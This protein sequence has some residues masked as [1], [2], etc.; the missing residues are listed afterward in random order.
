ME[1]TENQK[2][3]KEILTEVP[4][5]V[6]DLFSFENDWVSLSRWPKLDGM[7][8]HEKAM[9]AFVI[10][11]YSGTNKHYPKQH[12]LEHFGGMDLQKRQL[13]V[14]WCCKPFWL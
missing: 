13:I 11:I 5:W 1:L 12:I 6:S 14:D 8:P 4:R 3:F 9:T 10:M 2:R 7:S